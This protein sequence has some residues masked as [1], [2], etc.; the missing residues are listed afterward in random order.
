MLISTMRVPDM[1]PFFCVSCSSII[2]TLDEDTKGAWENNNGSLLLANVLAIV[3][4][5]L[6]YL[7]DLFSLLTK[8]RKITKVSFAI[9]GLKTGELCC[10]VYD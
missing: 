9:L 10:C 1:F 6:H 4:Q 2:S 7:Q 3:F 5:Y 8:E